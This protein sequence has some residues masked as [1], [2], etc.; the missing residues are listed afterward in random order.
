MD[1][2][3]IASKIEKLL[4]EFSPVL[5]EYGNDLVVGFVNDINGNDLV[6]Y[7]KDEEI[8]LTF[9]YQN[10][11]FEL[12]DIDSVVI[13]ATKYLKSEYCSVEFFA[14]AKDLF[15]GSRLTSTVNFDTVEG[16]IDCYSCGKEEAKKGLLELFRT[17]KDLSV[18]AVNFDNSINTVVMIKSD[19]ENITLQKIRWFMLGVL[20]N[21]VAIIVCS[22]LGIFLKK[23]INDKIE[24]LVMQAL[25]VCLIAIG[26]ADAINP[27]SSS[28]FLVMIISF[29]VGSII[30]EL[31]KIS[32]GLDNLGKLFEKGYYKI[33]PKNKDSKTHYFSEGFIQATMIFCVGAMVIYG[34]IQ[35]GL[36]DNKT[37]YIKACLD[38]IVAFL[39]AVKFGIGVMFSFIPVLL[40]QGVIALL[41][42]VVGDYLIAETLFMQQLSAIGGVFVLMIGINVLEIKKIKIANMLPAILGACYYLIF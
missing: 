40:I 15:G 36:G 7:V 21:S 13:H 2:A 31:L 30:G 35:A 10:A 33:I 28:G 26:L 4:K 20:V 38:G 6:I 22:I 25:G 14:K 5:V 32:N 23:I 11:H 37:L 9:G 18:R 3:N 16:I 41:S 29:A 1:K 39:L 17:T 34:S 12:T 19:G 42:T 27:V 8:V 24:V